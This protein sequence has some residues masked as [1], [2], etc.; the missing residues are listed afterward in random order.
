MHKQLQSLRLDGSSQAG[1]ALKALDPGYVSVDERSIKDLLAFAQKYSRELR[2]I[3]ERNEVE[4]D[5]SG[6]LGD[7]DLDELVAFLGDPEGFLEQA[8]DA[9]P[10]TRPHLVLFLTFL[11]LLQQARA[12]LN[13]LTRRHLEFY[14]REALRMTSRA[15]TPDRV[16]AL[17]KLADGQGQFLLPAGTTL[18]AGQDSQG[19]DIFYRSEKDLLANRASVEAVMSQFVEKQV[20]GIRE[21]RLNP[22]LLIEVIPANKDILEEGPLVDRSF[23]AMLMMAL[24]ETIPGGKLAPYPDGRTVDAALLGELDSLLD[25]VPATL[26]MPFATFRSLMQSKKD[27]EVAYGQWDQVNDYLEAAARLRLQDS[28]FKLDRSEPANF[29]K[30]LL[31]ALGRTAFGD[32]F[33]ELP[34]VEDIYDLYR[35]R[36]RDDVIDFILHSLYMSVEDFSKMMGIVEEINTRWRQVYEI[37]RAAGRKKQRANPAHELQPP[38][39]RTYAADKFAT[40]VEKT[41]GKIDYSTIQGTRPASFDDLYAM[42]VRLEGYFHIPAENFVVIRETNAN[43]DKARPWEWDQVYAILE[44]AYGEKVLADRRNALKTKREADGLPAMMRFALGDPKPG[45]K[46]PGER[47]FASIGPTPGDPDRDKQYIT[48]ELF[49]DVLNFNYIKKTD[50]EG[51]AASAEEWDNVYTIVELAQRRKRKWVLPPAEIEKWDNVY[52]AADASQVQVRLGADGES[53]TPRWRTFGEGYS[54][55]QD[56]SPARTTPGDVG[57]A[58]ASPLL[59][60]SEGKR[61]ITLTLAFDEQYFDTAS[62]EDAIRQ[63]SPFRF[64]LSTEKEMIAVKNATLALRK[65]SFSISGADKPYQNALQITLSLDEQTPAIAPLEAGTGI[66]MPWPVLQIMLADLPRP[67]R[68]S[69]GPQKRYRAFQSLQLRKIHLKVDADGITA[70]K[71]QNEAGLLDPKKP[72]E[73][74][75]GSPVT[76]SSFYLA[77]PELCSKELDQFNLTIDWL[78]APENFQTYYLGY[79]KSDVR[80]VDPATDLTTSPMADNT[81]L[82]AQLKLYDNRSFFNITDIQLFSAYDADKKTSAATTNRVGVDGKTIQKGYQNYQ[83]T[84]LTATTQEVLDWPRYW[85]LELLTPDFQHAVYPRVAAGCANKIVTDTS[86]PKPYIVNPPYTPKIKRLTAGYSASLELDLAVID[87]DQQPDRLYHIEPFGYHDLSTTESDSLAFLPQFEDEGE[88]FIG[89]KSLV[90]P[91]SL[92]LLFQMAEGS[93]DP[94]LEREPI[95]WSYLDGNR[96]NSLEEGRLLSDSTNGLLNAGV[97]EFDL[98]PAQ[99]GTLFPAD[100][101]WIRVAIPRNSRSVGDTVAIHAQAFSAIFDDHG[102]APDH[103]AQPLPPGSIS[104]LAEPR[105]QIGSVQ[106]PF[107]SFGGKNP[108]QAAGF[109][110]RVSERLRHKN[111]ALTCWDYEHMVLETFPGIYKVKCLPVGASDDPR[112]ADVI[113]I[114]VIPDIQGRL[115]FDPFEPK[116]PADTLWQIE[117]YLIGHSPAF[118]RLKVKNPTYVRLKARLGVRLREDSNPGYYKNLLNEELQR[119]LAPWAYDRSA[120]IVFGGRINTSLII[121]FLEERPYVDYVAGIKL[122]TSLDGRQFTLYGEPG[123]DPLNDV[124]VLAPDA[125]LVS[126]RSHQIDLIAEEGYEQEFFTGI[127][128]MKIELDFQIASG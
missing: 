35:R 114:V 93:A 79:L 73:P 10:F 14:Y 61:T 52:V 74:F 45:D 22:D 88:L 78:G 82:K 112:L 5:W 15:G 41:L 49:L 20:I 97:I 101:Y 39:I 60:L 17:V 72:F 37:L 95:R 4:G 21:A 46:L 71:L 38:E 68:P 56:E 118:A 111:R 25:F 47:E 90:P 100:K 59:A 3:N 103:L 40:L 125:I 108:E 53:V 107:S 127:N 27:Q 36:D 106:Q 42:I 11:E 80:D 23:L 44:A 99:T 87:L 43:P 105:S 98:P 121:N 69:E 29:E 63:P 12:Q 110:T 126:D 92:S 1:R 8:Q 96:W 30:N 102:N 58:I 31:A 55:P 13:E 83:R 50:A 54:P 75:G 104:G 34:E 124:S 65:G 64:L 76:G 2:Y 85:L 48:D 33:N 116:L 123:D 109:Y 81:R 32:F 86:T 117:Q 28:R 91:Q 89:I 6:F 7:H 119:Y 70:L 62:I 51:K 94:N 24:G 128:Y 26:Y 66:R 67:D 19:K 115:P 122:F 9:E 113:Q 18:R 120:E 84:L 77:H 16:H 57:F